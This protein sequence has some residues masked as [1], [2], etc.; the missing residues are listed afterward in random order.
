[1]ST[2]LSVSLVIHVRVWLFWLSVAVQQIVF[3]LAFG[4]RI[5]LIGIST[6]VIYVPVVIIWV[7]YYLVPLLS[8][9][10]EKKYAV[11][12]AYALTGWV[13]VAAAVSWSTL[14]IVLSKK[15]GT[16]V[17][18]ELYH[19]RQIRANQALV[20]T[21]TSVTAPAGQEPRQP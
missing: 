13:F 9:K 14:Y 6:W 7:L 19:E 21:P 17:S 11:L 4:L 16:P 15:Y 10:K 3:L 12:R 2:D 8:E 5:P 20:P 18:Y 1:M